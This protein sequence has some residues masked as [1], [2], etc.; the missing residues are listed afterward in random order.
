M[1]I[2]QI[3]SSINQQY[4]NGVQL[5]KVSPEISFFTQMSEDSLSFQVNTL[6]AL[7]VNNGF[8]TQIWIQ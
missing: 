7:T 2:F 3:F 5:K 8:S 6:N 1:Y 4:W